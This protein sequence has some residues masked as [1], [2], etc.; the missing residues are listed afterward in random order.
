[1][2][3]AEQ[4]MLLPLTS[5][6]FFAAA[7]IVVAH[8]QNAFGF[9]ASPANLSVAISFFFVLSG[10]ILTYRYP[11]LRGRR[12]IGRFYLARVARIW[13]LHVATLIVAVLL[14][15]TPFV[16]SGEFL[17]N[18]FLVQAWSPV[19]VQAMSFNGV[20]WTISDEAFFYLLLPLVVLSWRSRLVLSIAS[21]AFCAGVLVIGSQMVGDAPM[22]P[23]TEPSWYTVA[24]V[25]PAMR[26]LEFLI[27]CLACRLY[28]SA[29]SPRLP[30][31]LWTLLEAIC[32]AALLFAVFRGYLVQGWLYPY[33]SPLTYYWMLHAGAAPV[34][35]L[36][37]LCF[38]HEGG[39]FSR[40]LQNPALVL[41]GE[42]SFSTYM[43]HQLLIRWWLRQGWA[44][45][46]WN[47]PSLLALVATIYIASYLSWRFFETPVRRAILSPRRTLSPFLPGRLANPAPQPGRAEG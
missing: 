42:I 16:L 31:L 14:A 32:I 13:P 19:V 47:L 45:T 10:F 35:A 7:A 23:M 27:G 1:M 25:N 39:F 29:R 9:S 40:I 4:S 18:L 15:G 22:E 46:S 33:V 3:A 44:D 41:L 36:V 21:V 38:A 28:Q 24:H 17:A 43:I 6:R 5:L 12:A 37:I 34:L 8:L 26:F 20:A 30:F 2:V 11:V